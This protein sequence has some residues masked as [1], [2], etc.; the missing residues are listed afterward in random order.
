MMQEPAGSWLPF[1]V[2]PQV[3]AIV[4]PVLNYVYSEVAD[5][6]TIFFTEILI[7]PLGLSNVAEEEITSLKKF[8]LN[9]YYLDIKEGL[10]FW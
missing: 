3:P 5:L 7:L 4:C 9:K 8:T 2:Y 1:I 10:Q 6:H